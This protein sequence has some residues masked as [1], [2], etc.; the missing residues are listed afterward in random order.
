MTM[1][2]LET[3]EEPTNGGQQG[4]EPEDYRPSRLRT[5]G[6]TLFGLFMF[7]VF[8][9]LKL[10][11]ARIQNLI[12]A[13]IRIAAQ[14]QGLLF[15]AEKIRV[16]MLLG[17]SLKM[18]NVE[19]KSI[20]NERQTLKIP[21]LKIRPSLLSL[22]SSNKK[23]GFSAELLGG[24][25]SGSA[26]LGPTSMSLDLDLDSVDLGLTT[27][28]RKFLPVDVTA[29]INGTVT[30][31]L[32]QQQVQKSDGRI[33]LKLEKINLPAQG[34]YGFNVPKIAIG[35]SNVD[36]TIGQGQIIIRNFEVGKD[37]KTDDLVAKIT[38][39]GTLDRQLDR[40]RINAKAVFE[41]SSSV[42]QSFSLLDALLG[43][44]KGSDGKY[45]YRL[46]GPLSGLEATPGG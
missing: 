21:Y 41:L 35:Q 13:H 2:T 45:V 27:L 25:M 11:E 44:A 38:G 3:Y 1:E 36:I 34:V 17:P 16:G 19:L 14:D 32:D 15:S 6:V 22:L 39:D 40:S 28:L 42:L 23:V 5:I 33:R 24:S 9:V 4:Q 12:L 10:P 7:F 20:D 43:P 26:G 31:D 46:S 37:I 30:L 8:L 29:K 18:Y